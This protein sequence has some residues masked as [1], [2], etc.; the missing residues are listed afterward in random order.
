MNNLIKL[1]RAHV[2]L[3]CRRASGGTVPTLKP[4]GDSVLAALSPG[5]RITNPAEAEV[6]GMTA[7]HMPC[8]WRKE[9]S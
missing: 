4:D 2:G 6:L 7:A 9:A 8:A 5:R 3:P 1:L